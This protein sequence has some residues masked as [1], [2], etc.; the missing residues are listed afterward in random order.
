MKQALPD[1]AVALGER[2]QHIFVATSDLEE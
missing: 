1:A 2:L